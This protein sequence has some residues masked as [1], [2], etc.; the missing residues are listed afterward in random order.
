[1]QGACLPA[2]ST[3]HPACCLQS[4]AT[5]KR[6]EGLSLP[7]QLGG[8]ARCTHSSAVAATGTTLRRAARS[9]SKPSPAMASDCTTA[10]STLLATPHGTTSCG[11]TVRPC[12]SQRNMRLPLNWSRGP[13]G[14]RLISAKVACTAASWL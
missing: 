2:T 1:M 5:T 7:R 13:K 3:Q 11:G 14:A 6:F 8:G 10:P 12:K 4:G 9:Y